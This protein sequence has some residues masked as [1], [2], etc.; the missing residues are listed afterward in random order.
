MSPTL[1]LR[2]RVGDLAFI[3][4][5]PWIGRLVVVGARCFT[6]PF[7]WDV[8][9]LSGPFYW[10]GHPD[11]VFA[12]AIDDFLDPIRDPDEDAIDLYAPL[13]EPAKRVER[14][15][16]SDAI[17]VAVWAVRPGRPK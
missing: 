5:G 9:S 17:K 1:H 12:H 3:I 15:A 10:E 14:Q 4:R 16:G 11:S 7:D 13:V 8:R 2:C 6:A